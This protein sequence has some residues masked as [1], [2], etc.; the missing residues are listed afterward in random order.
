MAALVDSSL[1][2]HQL[3]KSGDPTKRARVNELLQNGAAAW[4][5]AVRLELWR[6]VTD[7]AERKT[8]R[9]YEAVLPDYDVSAAVW[10]LAV[11]MADRGRAAGVTAPFADLLIFACAKVHH[12]DLA[13][14]DA[15]FTQL[16]Q[17]GAPTS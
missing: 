13:H 14:D 9:H 16:E 5:P 6:G 8:L 7:D 11:R 3:R 10:E 12:V 15:H 1:W 2:V 4:C 17:L